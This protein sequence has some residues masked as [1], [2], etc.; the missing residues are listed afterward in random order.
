VA[1]PTALFLAVYLAAMAAATRVLRGPA[2]LA[3][4]PAGL[5]VAVV[6]GFC[7]WALAI[8][9]TVALVVAWQARPG[10]RRN[11]PGA[12]PAAAPRCPASRGERE[13]VPSR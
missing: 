13:L 9:A 4:V 8:P 6:L 12:R 2:R 3:A 1:V 7:G 11:R 5:A 10:A